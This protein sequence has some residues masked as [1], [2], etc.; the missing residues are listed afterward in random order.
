MTN[1]ANLTHRQA[2]TAKSLME[3]G[4]RATRARL[5]ECTHPAGRAADLRVLD[6]TIEKLNKAGIEFPS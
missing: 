1:K 5:N 4:E 6:A 2:G 3:T